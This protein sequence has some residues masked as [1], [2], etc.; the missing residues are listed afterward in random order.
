MVETTRGNDRQTGK[1]RDQS[2]AGRFELPDKSGQFGGYPN[3]QKNVKPVLQFV[4][5]DIRQTDPFQASYRDRV[6]AVLIRMHCAPQQVPSDRSD[7]LCLAS[8][9]HANRAD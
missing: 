7:L 6:N 2:Q 1:T 4:Y 9:S 8:R 3:L 5:P